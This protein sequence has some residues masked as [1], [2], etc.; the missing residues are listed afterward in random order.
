MSV[1]KARPV[2][3]PDDLAERFDKTTGQEEGYLRNLIADAGHLDVLEEELLAIGLMSMVKGM[4]EDKRLSDD[5]KPL[6]VGRL[7]NIIY[8]IVLGYCTGVMQINEN[9]DVTLGSS[10]DDTKR[11]IELVQSDKIM[12]ANGKTMPTD[13]FVGKTFAIA[14]THSI[15][16]AYSDIVKRQLFTK[17]ISPQAAF[18]VAKTS[19]IAAKDL[20]E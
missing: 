8:M 16:E 9:G 11:A 19:I 3:V 14:S 1:F 12:F 6:S 5:E 2:V 18:S 20:M 7:S 4:M 17:S 10:L 15:G 13:E